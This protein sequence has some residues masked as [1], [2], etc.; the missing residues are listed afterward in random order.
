MVIDSE[1]NSQGSLSIG[2]M[3]IPGESKKEILISTYFCHPSL[4]NDNLSGL[5]MT[6]FLAR[7][8]A[9]RKKLKFISNSR[10]S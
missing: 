5:I 8:L 4:A 3:L 10:M 2:E 6:T 9:N 1:F 7:E